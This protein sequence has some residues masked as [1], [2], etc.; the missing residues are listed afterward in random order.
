VSGDKADI[1]QQV[2]VETGWWELSHCE[3]SQID[4]KGLLHVVVIGFGV[5][6]KVNTQSCSLGEGAA[7]FCF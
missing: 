3:Y 5:N 2:A 1:V 4:L 7:D 6:F